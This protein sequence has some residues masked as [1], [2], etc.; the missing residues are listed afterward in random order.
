MMLDTKH[1][2]LR[3]IPN[4]ESR[5]NTTEASMSSYELFIREEWEDIEDVTGP[6][7]FEMYNIFIERHKFASCSSRTFIANIKAFTSTKIKT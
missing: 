2:N 5:D 3:K 6:E 7:S 1:Y 4:T